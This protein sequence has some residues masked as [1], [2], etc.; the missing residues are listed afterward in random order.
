MEP[1]LHPALE[2]PAQMKI[3]QGLREEKERAWLPCGRRKS[4]TPNSSM[5][6][7]YYLEVQ[8]LSGSIQVV[9]LWKRWDSLAQVSVLFCAGKESQHLGPQ[10]AVH[11]ATGEKELL[12]R[13]RKMLRIE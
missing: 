3:G 1:V 11:S 8:G 4:T 10:N 6:K 12:C 5:D 7:W 2:R 9:M 13:K